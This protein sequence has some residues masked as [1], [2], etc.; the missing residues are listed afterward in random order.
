MDAADALGFTDDLSPQGLFIK[1]RSIFAPGT[2]LKIELTLPDDQIIRLT[3]QVM[4]AKRVDPSMVR[5]V[6][7]SG[8]GIRIVQPPPSYD[9]FVLGLPA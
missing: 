4:W 5:F 9:Q 6:K 3:G 7:K 8:M 1:T 2:V